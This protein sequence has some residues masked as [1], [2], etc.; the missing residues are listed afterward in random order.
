MFKCIGTQ[1][2]GS[3]CKNESETPSISPVTGKPTTRYLCSDCASQSPRK[4]SRNTRGI[5][6]E[7]PGVLPNELS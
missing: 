7:R 6:Q 3:P 2:D 4:G 1:A 5:V